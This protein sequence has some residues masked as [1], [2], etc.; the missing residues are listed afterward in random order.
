MF[1]L[2]SQKVKK[3]QFKSLKTKTTFIVFVNWQHLAKKKLFQNLP[4]RNSVHFRE[5]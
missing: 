3:K 2:K 5:S 1:L 4:R